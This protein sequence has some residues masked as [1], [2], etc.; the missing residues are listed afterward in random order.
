MFS[1]ISLLSRLSP[2]R[3]REEMHRAHS[4]ATLLLIKAVNQERESLPFLC[5]SLP[6]S[7]CVTLIKAAIKEEPISSSKQQN[8]SCLFN[9]RLFNSNF[10]RVQSLCCFSCPCFCIFIFYSSLFSQK[11]Q[12][13]RKP[14]GFIIQYL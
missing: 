6:G 3:L 10:W 2:Q 1:C 5:F 9:A 8:F 14:F 13:L 4:F 11:V 7:V 12:P